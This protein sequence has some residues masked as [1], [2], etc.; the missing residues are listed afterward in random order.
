VSVTKAAR[1]PRWA[2]EDGAFER[3]ARCRRT[4]GHPEQ[5]AY[6]KIRRLFLIRGL[7]GP[8]QLRDFSLLCTHSLRGYGQ[9]LRRS[10]A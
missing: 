4:T 2:G 10:N 9:P 3:R 1:Q 7:P 8:P 5:S 6:Y